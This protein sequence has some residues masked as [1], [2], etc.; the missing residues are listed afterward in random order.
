[1]TTTATI[2]TKTEY[3]KICEFAGS[4]F[5]YDD[6]LIV[7]KYNGQVIEDEILTKLLNQEDADIFVNMKH[8]KQAIIISNLCGKLFNNIDNENL[9]VYSSILSVAISINSKEKIRIP[10]IVI[11]PKKEI[12][13][14]NNYVT[15]PLVIFEV[16]SPSSVQTD[17]IDKLRE[18]KTLES[19]Q[20]YII[21]EQDKNYLVHYQRISAA[22]W[23]E[24]KIE[25]D[26][27]FLYLP[28]VAI[29]LELQEI[30]ADCE[31]L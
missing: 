4:H 5:E 27:D 2:Y 8:L 1:M 3:D 23:T 22:E 20:E 11:T 16:V 9:R 10:D 18:Y 13:L 31:S 6:G 24:E 26:N 12:L 17:Y 30:Y 19:L 29:K 21:V 15:N 28:T 14:D 7:W 25:T